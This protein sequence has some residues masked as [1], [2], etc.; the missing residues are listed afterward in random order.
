[1]KP[2][3]LV[4]WSFAFACAA[5]FVIVV[6]AVGH[7]VYRAEFPRLEAFLK[8]RDGHLEALLLA[9]VAAALA[10]IIVYLLGW[11]KKAMNI[12]LGT[13]KLYG[14]AIPLVFWSVSFVLL[15]AAITTR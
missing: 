9:V 12:E 2:R 6:G 3:A 8:I 15:I 10:T 4:E 13:T 1:M 7:D 5:L 14:L 11:G